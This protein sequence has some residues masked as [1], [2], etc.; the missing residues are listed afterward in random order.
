[1]G[2]LGNFAEG[3]V[4]FQKG[5]DFTLKI[6]NLFSLGLLELDYGR[7]QNI[8]GDGKKAIEHSQNCIRYCE[9]GQI[10]IYLGMAWSR[11]G[12]GYCLLEK[13]ETARTHMEKGLKISSDAGLHYH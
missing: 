6:K 4:L 5:L 3:K 9:E 8:K 1:M 11:L 12:W 10:V 13:L 2:M 7:M